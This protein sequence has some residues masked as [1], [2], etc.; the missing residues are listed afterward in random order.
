MPTTQTLRAAALRDLLTSAR[1][2]SRAGGGFADH[3]AG[4]A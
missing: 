2:R 1:P 3:L 4:L